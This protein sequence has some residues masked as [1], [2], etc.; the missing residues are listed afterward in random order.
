MDREYAAKEAEFEARFQTHPPVDNMV[1]R[2]H[3]DI[4]EE[5]RYVAK[6]VLRVVPPGREQSL[7]ITKLEEAMFWANAGIARN[8]DSHDEDR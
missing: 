6:T 4:R 1:V 3:T 5:I 7:A 8:Q 2:A